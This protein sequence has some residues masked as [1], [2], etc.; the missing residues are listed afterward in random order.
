MN[1]ATSLPVH[2][3]LAGP[4][5]PMHQD[6]TQPL[7]RYRRYALVSVEARERGGKR[8][9]CSTGTQNAQAWQIPIVTISSKRGFPR[10]SGRA[11]NVFGDKELGKNGAKRVIL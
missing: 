1:S 5:R 11:G 6:D 2:F 10:S 8:A 9:Q 4:A 3:R 7:G